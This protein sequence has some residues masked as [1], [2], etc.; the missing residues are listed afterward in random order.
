MSSSSD[1]WY[2]RLGVGIELGPMPHEDLIELAQTGQLLASDEVRDGSDGEWCP[3]TRLPDLF[4]DADSTDP[5]SGSSD[6][7]QERGA[8]NVPLE[9]ASDDSAA[10]QHDASPPEQSEAIP[11]A[12][13]LD[14]LEVESEQPTELMA[15]QTPTPTDADTSD[16]PDFELNLPQPAPDVVADLKPVPDQDPQPV[17]EQLDEPDFEL[18]LPQPDPPTPAHTTPAATFTDLPELQPP[19]PRPNS[20]ARQLRS[21]SVQEAA[22]PSVPMQDTAPS[23]LIEP[24]LPGPDRPSALDVMKPAATLDADASEPVTLRRTPLSRLLRA[25]SLAGAAAALLSF[26][27]WLLPGPERDIYTD[28][29]AIYKELRE[30]KSNPNDQSG[31]NEFAAHSKT[32]IDDANPWLEET[33]MP[34]DRDRNLLLYAGRDL[35]KLLEKS[36]DS[37]SPHQ[38]RL[39]GFFQQLEEIYA[40]SR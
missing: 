21:E 37:E 20:P 7:Q 14:E 31:W 32:L 28:Y 36:P 10:E 40:S 33:A 3:A 2:A 12:E 15:P 16:E 6:G 34:G 19:P 39:D 8:A 24:Q 1:R 35:R 29:L 4:G 13:S 5:A 30:R 27:W 17:P 9:T 22:P 11:V 25:L 23:P 38:Q 18:N 26:I